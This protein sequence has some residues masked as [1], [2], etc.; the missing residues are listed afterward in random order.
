MN[1]L[2][3]TY[4]FP[5]AGGVG[6]LRALSLAKYLPENGVRVDVLT[7]R[8]A[9]AVGRDLSLLQQIPGEVTVHRTWTL[10]LPFWLR[11]A[12]KKAVTGGKAKPA[13]VSGNGSGGGG[14]PL[15]QLIGNLLLPDPQV[16]WL[17]FALPAAERIIRER[18]I[19]AVVVTVPPFSSV[20]LVTR[21]R[22]IFP[23]LPILVDFRDEWLTT[24]L[25]LVSFNSN[26]RARMVAHKAEA[27]AVRDA[28]AVVLVTEAARRE[29]QARYPGVAKQRFVCI[30]NGYDTPPPTA[31][32]TQAE[33][34]AP[35]EKVVLTYIGT[36]YGSTAPGTFV[37]A[38]LGLPGAVRSR[39]LVR[40]IGHIETP[41]YREQLLSLGDTIEL[42]G[43]V[44]QAEALA[45]IHDTTYLLLITHDRINVAAKFYD[46][47]GGG[48]PILGAVHPE[49]EVRRLLEETRAGRWA[50]VDDAQAIRRMIVEAIE[51]S[52]SAVQ[53]DYERIA[54]YHRRPL[55]ARYVALLRELTGATSQTT[56]EPTSR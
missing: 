18:A 28:T 49:G 10:D 50:S 48:K 27:E 25:D 34:I 9:P 37:E 29:L 4:S 39:L 45:A 31:Q 41:A 22:S 14:N 7:A 5:P 44:P 51:G 11:K 47:L 3:I 32:S 43:F 38:V 56:G 12:V 36:V 24:T 35:I 17:P 46:Y 30:P 40:F 54:A 42:K 15:K 23:A 2:L 8:N 33:P 6:V 13:A 16:G 21:L 53:P 26:S 55:A 19:D 20:R 52:S 1:L